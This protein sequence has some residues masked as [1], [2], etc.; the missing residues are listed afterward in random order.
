M[1]WWVIQKPWLSDDYLRRF[2]DWKFFA[3]LIPLGIRTKFFNFLEFGLAG[4]FSKIKKSL[5]TLKIISHMIQK[6]IM[7]LM[8]QRPWISYDSFPRYDFFKVGNFHK[9]FGP[10]GKNVKISLFL[11]PISDEIGRCSSINNPIATALLW[12]F[13]EI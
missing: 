12:L 4:N 10:G 1:T 13:L 8:V 5:E 9:Y 11:N 6:E 7:R 2:S 3:I